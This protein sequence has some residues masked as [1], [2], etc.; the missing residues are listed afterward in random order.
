MKVFVIDDSPLG[1]GRLHELLAEIPGISVVAQLDQA[2][3]LKEA[4]QASQPD[5]LILDIQLLRARGLEILEELKSS[6][7][8]LVKI[9][10]TTFPNP[11]YRQR[12][13]DAGADYFLDKAVEFEMIVNVLESL[14][15]QRSTNAHC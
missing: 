7:R 13:L 11:L 1:R 9:M 4:I 5:V 14:V 6:E 12:C 3:D 10:L 2:S 15:A 8:P